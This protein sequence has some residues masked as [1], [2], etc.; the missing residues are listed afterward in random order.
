MLRRY[1]SATGCPTAK[2]KKTDILSVFKSQH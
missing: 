2:A 1:A